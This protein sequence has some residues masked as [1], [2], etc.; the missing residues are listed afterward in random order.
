MT[1]PFIA[2]AVL[3]LALV[4]VAGCANESPADRGPSAPA[5]VETAAGVLIFAVGVYFLFWR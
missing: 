5:L 2:P 3:L 4:L 1:R